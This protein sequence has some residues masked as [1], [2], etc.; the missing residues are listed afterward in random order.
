MSFLSK[1]IISLFIVKSPFRDS[2][3]TMKLNNLRN[4]NT[5]IMQTRLHGYVVLNGK[6]TLKHKF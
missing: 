1:N 3:K 5:E 2:H 6:T 4:V